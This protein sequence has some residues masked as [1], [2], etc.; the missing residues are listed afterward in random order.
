MNPFDLIARKQRIGKEY[1]AEVELFVLCHFDAA[2][3]GCV[4]AQGF[5]FVSYHLVM[6]QYIFARL[7]CDSYLKL[8]R[9]AGEAW[10][11]SGARPGEH[12]SL[13][14][15]EYAAMRTGL[16]VYFRTLP[17]IEAGTYRQGCNIADQLMK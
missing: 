2:K 12:A 11:K 3:R 4:T 13:T 10:Q 17:Q 6:A 7:K 5:N 16:K 15:T 9:A 1:A 8:A 14:T